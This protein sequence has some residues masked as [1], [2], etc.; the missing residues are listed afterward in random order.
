M[1]QR[2]QDSASAYRLHRA[3]TNEAEAIAT[4]IWH[5]G[6]DSF[7]LVR[8]QLRLLDAGTGDGQ[9]LKG[10]LE[11]ALRA[12]HRRSCTVVLKEYDFQHIEV[13]LQNVAPILQAFPQLALFV[14]NRRFRDLQGFPADLC[15]DNTVCFDDVAGYRLLARLATSSLLSQDDSLLHTF[16]QLTEPQPGSEAFALSLP[17]RHLWNAEHALLLPD[18]LDATSPALKALGDEIRAREIYDELQTVGGQGGH[19]TVAITRQE[20]AA[21]AFLPPREFFWDLAIVSHA[22]NRDKDP[23]WICR[24]ILRPLAQGLSVGGILANVHAID[25]GQMGELQ[26]EIFADAF[27]FRVLP[28]AL[29]EAMQATLDQDEFALMPAQEFAYHGQVTAAQF[30]TLE[31]WEQERVLEQLVISVTYHLQIPDEA[32]EP[33]RDAIRKKICAL[34]E[35][36]GKLTYF[37]SLVGIK[38]RQ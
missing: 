4:A 27:P 14:T 32:W 16:P 13:L 25:R 7:R 18:A 20:Q 33:Y 34:L 17:Q 12:H 19:F 2:F 30:A 37:L 28:Q 26:R 24:N 1:E 9:V 5:Y 3:I 31:A 21:T 23:V 36:D 29:T 6:E 11:Q 10:V 15:R 38:R 35:R 8:S 22:F